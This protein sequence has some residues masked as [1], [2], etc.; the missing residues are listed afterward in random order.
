MR[1]AAI[2]A[3]E[4][5]IAGARVGSFVVAWHEEQFP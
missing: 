5:D 3:W 1:S 4:P 2:K